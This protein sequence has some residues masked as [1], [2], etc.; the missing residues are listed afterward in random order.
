MNVLG[1]K[2]AAQY[3]N[4]SIINHINILLYIIYSLV[5]ISFA[6]SC[7]AVTAQ[8]QFQTPTFLCRV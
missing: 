4:Q 1:L 3:I 8:V 7:C 6:L 2:A 5:T